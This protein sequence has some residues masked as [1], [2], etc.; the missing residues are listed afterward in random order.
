[1]IEILTEFG[2]KLIL[3]LFPLEEMAPPKKEGGGEGGE[4]PA[5]GNVINLSLLELPQL[6]QLKSQVE[7][8]LN[9]YQEAVVQLKDVQVKMSESRECL[10]KLNKD[11]DKKEMLVPV[12]GSVRSLPSY[13]RMRSIDHFLLQ[14]FVRGELMDVDKMLIDIGTGY[15]V[16]K[17]R[18]EFFEIV[19]L[20][21]CSVSLSGVIFHLFQTMPDAIDY[22]DRKV[23]FLQTQIEKVQTVGREKSQIRGGKLF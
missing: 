4:G 11:K 14:M 7:Q 8:E 10:R 9:F 21:F 3:L 13:A 17:V 19:N 2:S 16:E 1:M 15:Y 20:L 22:F 5:G 23:K 12:T 6:Q 18:K